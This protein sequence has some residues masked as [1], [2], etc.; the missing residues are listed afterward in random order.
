MH[1]ERVQ[2]EAKIRELTGRQRM[3][4]EEINALVN[5][6][7]GLRR[8]PID[9]DPIDRAQ[10]YRSGRVAGTANGLVAA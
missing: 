5:A 8:I 9:A 2:A 6:L 3:T 1:A 7:G 10:V 4:S